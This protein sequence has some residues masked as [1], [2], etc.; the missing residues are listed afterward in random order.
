MIQSI[1]SG[2]FT[3]T[4]QKTKDGAPS[5][6]VMSERPKG[7]ATLYNRVDVVKRHVECPRFARLSKRR[8]ISWFCSYF[9]GSFCSCSCFCSWRPTLAWQNH[10]VDARSTNHLFGLQL[11]TMI[12]CSVSPTLRGGKAL[13]Q[14]SDGLS[15]T[16][17]AHELPCMR[18]SCA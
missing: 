1:G 13:N 12:R 2:I 10:P 4:L 16:R 3:P 7:R 18:T 5:V 9:L 8:R 17:V 11:P 6:L 15:S 14:P